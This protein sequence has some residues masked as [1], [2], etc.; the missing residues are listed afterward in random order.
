MKRASRY[1]DEDL[2]KSMLS[3]NETLLKEYYTVF[4]TS[5]RQFV[6]FNN[7]SEEDARDIF[8]DVLLVLYQKIRKD[9]F[10][11]T[12]TLGTYIYSIARLLWL[13]ELEKRKRNVPGPVDVDEFIEPG[14][15][16]V[17]QAEYNERMILYRNVFERLSNDCKRI[18]SLFL[19]G[20]PIAEI[21]KQMGY[22][23]DQ[24]TK[25]RRYRCKIALLKRIRLVYGYKELVYEN[26]TDDRSIPG[27]Y[28]KR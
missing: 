23:N 14:E 9:D 6:L 3:R 1:S 24:H 25:N 13:K 16:I 22:K 7:G 2:L 15:G 4:Y 26:N 10:V 21:T 12:C 18:L 28:A 8:Q 19:E 5:I 20:L 17:E 11:L 27:W